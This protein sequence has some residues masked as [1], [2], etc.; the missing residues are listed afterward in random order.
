MI[1]L[2]DVKIILPFA[3]SILHC[4]ASMDFQHWPELFAI[5][6][7]T[8][9]YWRWTSL[10]DAIGASLQFDLL[11][12]ADT[13]IAL[14]KL[15]S[16]RTFTVLIRWNCIAKMFRFFVVGCMALKCWER[17]A[18]M[19]PHCYLFSAAS[20][21]YRSIL[22]IRIWCLCTSCGCETA[23]IDVFLIR[24]V[25]PEPKKFSMAGAGAKNF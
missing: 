25:E 8:A 19:F 18:K 20:L 2:K 14:K 3:S 11:S 10:L 17:L 7:E 6:R 9:W 23:L 15:N 1:N 4:F 5:K 22:S 13:V 12:K 24:A 16:S 21:L